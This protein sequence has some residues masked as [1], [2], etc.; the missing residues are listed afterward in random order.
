MLRFFH[1]LKNQNLSQQL[2][3]VVVQQDWRNHRRQDDGQNQAGVDVF[4][5]K[6]VGDAD[7]GDDQSHF[8]PRHH[9]GAN[10]AAFQFG[11]TKG[12]S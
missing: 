7:L 10:N 6:M 11:H 4:R 12:L 2:F 1:A 8:P 9:A 3:D 5:E